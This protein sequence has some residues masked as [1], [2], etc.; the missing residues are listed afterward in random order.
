ME[1][2]IMITAA[3]VAARMTGRPWHTLL[4]VDGHPGARRLGVVFRGTLVQALAAW[5][6][7]PWFAI[8][9]SSLAFGLAHGLPMAGFVATA[10]L[11]LAAAWLTVR[12]TPPM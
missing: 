4:S 7:P 5:V 2:A 12:R 3:F 8:L 1:M 11:G 6:R 10:T 9:V